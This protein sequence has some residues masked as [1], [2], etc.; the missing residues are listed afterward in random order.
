MDDDEPIL[1]DLPCIGSEGSMPYA[2]AGSPP[3]SSRRSFPV[4][5]T[6]LTLLFI[7]TNVLLGG[8]ARSGS[9][10][11]APLWLWMLCVVELVLLGLLGIEIRA[12]HRQRLQ[13]RGASQHD[14]GG[15]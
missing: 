1:C 11:L 9:F 2:S 15:P 3:T 12:K 6:L 7:N 13:A 8:L 10:L 5:H 14:V 4:A